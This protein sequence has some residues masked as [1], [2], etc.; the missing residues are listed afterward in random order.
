MASNSL[1]HTETP[2]G[3]LNKMEQIQLLKE[4]LELARKKQLSFVGAYANVLSWAI[5]KL[6]A[7]SPEKEE[8]QWENCSEGR[9][10]E[11][12][13]LESSPNELPLIERVDI[14]GVKHPYKKGGL[15]IVDVSD[16]INEI[17]KT[18]NLLSEEL[19]RKKL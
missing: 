18:V 9:Y 19:N 10:C 4:L 1:L 7:D 5:E 6:E 11:R 17:I 3:R 8:C 15:D 16:K 12:H 13:S 2:R 14:I